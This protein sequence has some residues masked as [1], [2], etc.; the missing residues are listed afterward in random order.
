MLETSTILITGGEIGGD[1][2]GFGD[3]DGSADRTSC[4]P[5]ALSAERGVASRWGGEG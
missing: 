2:L 5:I 3:L 4:R 1:S